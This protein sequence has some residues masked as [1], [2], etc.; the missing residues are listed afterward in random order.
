MLRRVKNKKWDGKAGG[1]SS[2]RQVEKGKDYVII[3]IK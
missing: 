3:N 2:K 1:R